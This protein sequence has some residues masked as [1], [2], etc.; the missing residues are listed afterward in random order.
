MA[1]TYRGDDGRF[2]VNS[3]IE[4]YKESNLFEKP[5][6]I[7]MIFL[8]DPTKPYDGPLSLESVF[9][10]SHQHIERFKCRKTYYYHDDMLK[11]VEAMRENDPNY[12]ATSTAH[13]Y[14]LVLLSA[15]EIPNFRELI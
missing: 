2:I 7:R 10:D 15:S 13:C 12:D 11:Y 14:G 5:P 9:S 4:P 8:P 6:M 1:D 3:K